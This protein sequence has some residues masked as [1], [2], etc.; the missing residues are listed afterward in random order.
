MQLPRN[1]FACK[2]QRAL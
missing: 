2:F 1:K